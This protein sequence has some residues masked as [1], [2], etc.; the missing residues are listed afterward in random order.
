MN[1]IKSR[2]RAILIT[3]ILSATLLFYQN[4]GQGFKTLDMSDVSALSSLTDDADA[5]D[6][7]S[8][9]PMPV[10]IEGAGGKYNLAATLPPGTPKG[11]VF[12][13]DPTGAPLPPG[14]ILSDDGILSV[15]SAQAGLT[16]GVRFN[17]TYDE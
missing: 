7:W 5:M 4:C 6:G 14:M 2:R 3:G 17:Y 9:S 15:N 16:S 12:S 10:F 11:G 13:V 1:K 8:L